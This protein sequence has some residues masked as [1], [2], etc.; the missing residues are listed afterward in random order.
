MCRSSRYD[1]PAVAAPRSAQRCSGRRRRARPWPVAAA[2]ELGIAAGGFSAYRTGRLITHGSVRAAELNAERVVELERALG[3]Y[4]EQS[5]QRAAL[6]ADW[7]VEVLNHYY[8]LVH[9]PATTAFLIWTFARHRGS[10]PTIRTWLAAVTLLALV[11]HVAF[12]LAPPRMRRG[13]VDTLD[14]FGPSIYP[15]DPGHSLANQFAAM[16]S[17]HFGW[18]L[19]VAIGI[20]SLTHRFRAIWMIHPL[21]TLLAIV[22][23]GNHYWTDAA[24]ATLLVAATGTII[25]RRDQRS[26]A[27]G[28]DR[29]SSTHEGRCGGHPVRSESA[30]SRATVPAIDDWGCRRVCTSSPPSVCRRPAELAGADQASRRRFLSDR[31]EDAAARVV[32]VTVGQTQAGTR[33]EANASTAETAPLIDE[34]LHRSEVS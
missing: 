14:R 15:A 5:I 7:I 4:T 21:V 13:F 33:W 2:V 17:L 8:V 24:I 19:V 3:V 18:A 30:S 12:P 22:A 20:A 34:Y 6:N 25:V 9:F 1:L 23:T 28:I 29:V 31:H 11:I 16:P 27:G 32:A 10:Y 26:I